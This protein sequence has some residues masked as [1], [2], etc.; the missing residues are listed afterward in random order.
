MADMIAVRMTPEFLGQ[1][2]TVANAQGYLSV[3]E[4]VRDAVRRDIYRHHKTWLDALVKGAKGKKTRQLTPEDRMR[5][6]EEIERETLA[7]KR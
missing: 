7:K 3:Q 6:F 2:R 5:I 4:Y 1:V